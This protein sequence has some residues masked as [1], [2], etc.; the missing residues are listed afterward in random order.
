MN[1]TASFPE[2]DTADVAEAAEEHAL[3]ALREMHFTMVHSRTEAPGSPGIKAWKGTQHILVQINAAVAPHEPAAL[4]LQER[5]ELRHRAADAGAVA[6]EA[7]VVLGPGMELV[8]LEW[9]P[10]G[11]DGMRE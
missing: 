5:H 3:A 6:W 4:N 8:R 7:R 9:W 11:L 2:I 1:T 10:L